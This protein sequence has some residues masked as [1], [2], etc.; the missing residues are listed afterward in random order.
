[1]SVRGFCWLAASDLLWDFFPRLNSLEPLL[2]KEEL[3]REEFIEPAED[4][5]TAF[6]ES[7]LDVRYIC[8]ESKE[9]GLL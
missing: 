4:V 2:R 8:P 5:E 6:P 9:L 7:S 1:M 3:L